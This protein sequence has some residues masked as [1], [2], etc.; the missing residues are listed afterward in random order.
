MIEIIPA[1]DIINGKCVRL[2]QGDFATVKTY[3][4]DPVSVVR[5]FEACGLKRLHM[6]DLDGAKSGTISNRHVLETVAKATNLKIDF[7][8]GLNTAEDF[9]KVFEAGASIAAVG[10]LA[11]KDPALLL[12]MLHLYGP[13]RILLGADVR[14]GK[15][16]INGWQTPTDL[17]VIP[18]LSEFIADGGEQAFVTDISRD[19]LLQGPST[20]LYSEIVA[21]LPQLKIIASGGVSTI[22]DIDD[23]E[24]VGC[25]GVIVGKAI[26][27]RTISLSD[28]TNRN[29][30]IVATRK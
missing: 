11:V 21:S 28:L 4:D 18:F 14:D 5:Q 25:S 13:K 7:G 29:K 22:R 6:V 3:S 9:R 27:E 23:L 1:I 10:S 2:S 19:G 17:D 30:R 24:T 8:G 12:R 26:Y 16:A 15:L 20:N